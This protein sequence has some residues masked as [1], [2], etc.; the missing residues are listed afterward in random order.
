[1]RGTLLICKLLYTTFPQ[2]SYTIGIFLSILLNFCKELKYRSPMSTLSIKLL[3]SHAE[4]AFDGHP[5]DFTGIFDKLPKDL[6]VE[7]RRGGLTFK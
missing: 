4:Y 5:F 3:L 2:I 1:M 7:D 6:E